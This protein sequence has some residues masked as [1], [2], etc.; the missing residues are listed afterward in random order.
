[1]SLLIKNASPQSILL[2]T[3]DLSTR[4]IKPGPLEIPQHLLKSYIFARK[5]ATVPTPTSGGPMLLQYGTD[6]FD[7]N[8]KYY[9]HATRFAVG[10][11][12]TGSTVMLQRVIPDDAGIKSNI[13][14]Y[15]DIV[16]DDIPN[17]KRLSTGDYVLDANGDPVV[18][19]SVAT[20]RGVRVNVVTEVITDPAHVFGT[21]T[22][23]AGNLTGK[24]SAGAAVTS[25]MYPMLELVGAYQGEA[26][27]NIGISID[28]ILNDALDNRLLTAN[29][30]LPYKLSL[31]NRVDKTSTPVRMPSLYGEPNVMFTF[32]DKAISPLTDARYDFEAVF[33][34]NWYNEK[35]PLL[36]LKY[37]DFENRKFY[38]DNYELVLGLVMANESAHVSNVPAVWDD[39]LSASTASWFDFAKTDTALLADPEQFYLLDIFNGQ[40]SKSKHYF[41]LVIDNNVT[42]AVGQSVTQ[43]SY[44]TPI[45]M[46]GGSDGTMSNAMYETLVKREMA[47]YLDI[48]SQVMDTAINIESVM[49]DSGFT[50]ETKKELCNFIAVRKDTAVILGTHDASLGEKTLPLSDE[51]A[52]AVALKTRL[53]LT[54]ESTYFG[55]AV[56]RGVVV[57]GTG[58]MPDNSTKDAIPATYSILVKSSKMMGAGDGKWK[59]VELFDKAPGNIMKELINYQPEFI[60]AG[61]KPVLWSDGIVWAQPYDRRQYHFPAIQTVYENDTSVLNSWFTVAAIC[62]LQKIADWAWRNFTG[63]VALT[64]A[65]FAQQV[66]DFVNLNIKDRFAGMFVVIPEVVFTDADNQRGYSYNLII[67]I[68]SPNMKQVQVSTIEAHRMSDLKA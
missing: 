58:R 4:V 8:K 29:K 44:K 12:G 17:Y 65:E 11:V 48:N 21:A 14:V 24:D 41:T 39:G 54:P 23:K 13:V 63:S 47:K 49:Y 46:G 15:L 57:A 53:K 38:R 33:D 7:S 18:D 31:F 28:K 68:Y 66:V 20:V 1:M 10:A 52:I 2:G 32:R 37:N 35:N 45:F 43:L 67:K 9:N 51:R 27:N 26:Y 16:E 25:T 6:T 59:A 19:S 64:K 56:M 42:P 34:S 40:S 62:T 3:K 60:P 55:T 22:P 61:I 5:G 36:E 50:L 30:A